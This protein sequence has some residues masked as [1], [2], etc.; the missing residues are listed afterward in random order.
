[1]PTYEYIHVEQ[2]D[3]PDFETFQ[4]MSEDALT[5]CPACGKPIRKALTTPAITVKKYGQK[6]TESVKRHLKEDR[7]H[8]IVPDTKEKVVFKGPKSGWRRQAYNAYL[9]AKP[10]LKYKDFHLK[11]T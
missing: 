8:H 3:C 5:E 6:P 9:K 1:M 2:S 11:N 10:D 4:K 7:P